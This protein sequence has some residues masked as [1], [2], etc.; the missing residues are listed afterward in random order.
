MA[1]ALLAPLHAFRFLWQNKL[2]LWGSIAAHALA[3]CLYLFAIS[4]WGIPFLQSHLSP[5]LATW[6]ANTTALTV[7]ST[8]FLVS[9]YLLAIILYSIIGISIANTLLSPLF[10]VIAARSYEHVSGMT[11]PNLGFSSFAKSFL[12]E[13]MKIALVGTILLGTI[14]S[15]VLLFLSPLVFVFSVWFFGWQ[16]IDRTLGLLGLNWRKRIWFGLRHFPACLAFGIWFYVPFLSTVCAFAMTSAAAIVAARV[17]SE[18][19]KEEMQRLTL[20]KPAPVSRSALTSD[21]DRR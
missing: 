17:Q 4:Q 18:S 5:H 12:F 16:E 14:L 15:T 7:F 10:D 3:F 19:E 9:I 8:L 1:H 6:T 2:L 20:H 11:I 21:D 13:I